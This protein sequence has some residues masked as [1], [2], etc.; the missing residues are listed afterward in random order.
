MGLKNLGSQVSRSF[1][2]AL[3]QHTI[4]FLQ[5]SCAGEPTLHDAELLPCTSSRELQ[6]GYLAVPVLLS[7]R[8]SL[9]L[10]LAP[11]VEDG[12]TAWIPCEV[13]LNFPHAQP[14]RQEGEIVC[15]IALYAR[16]AMKGTPGELQEG[17]PLTPAWLRAVLRRNEWDDAIAVG[18]A[19]S[20]TA[21]QTAAQYM[22]AIAKEHDE[23]QTLAGSLSPEA[24]DIAERTARR[25]RA[26]VQ[27]LS[28]R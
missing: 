26:E 20:F 18:P 19:L 21:A 5:R 10:P 15:V 3:N 28:L 17:L 16:N 6:T 1:A 12:P 23:V 14:P 7:L 9:E 13:R 25:F 22:Y 11:A 24:L 27:V 2:L 8:A 4:R